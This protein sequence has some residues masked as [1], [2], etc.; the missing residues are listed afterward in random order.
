[1]G[2]AERSSATCAKCD[3]VLT[4]V[5][6]RQ[7]FGAGSPELAAFEEITLRNHMAAHPSLYVAC[8]GP[9]CPMAY[10]AG[11]P[12]AVEHCS[13]SACGTEF[14]SRCRGPFHGVP[15]DPGAT[16]G[17][18]GDTAAPG[19]PQRRGVSCDEA[20]AAVARWHAWLGGE[21]AAYLT[22]IGASRDEAQRTFSAETQ[23][24]MARFGKWGGAALVSGAAH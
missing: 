21:R 13:C 12:G 4:A 7:L 20:A 1:M 3:H 9:G 18:A 11:A 14:C 19:A 24:A 15:A 8:P 22:R 10:A 6:M 23:A 17:G 5:E 16:T 2:L